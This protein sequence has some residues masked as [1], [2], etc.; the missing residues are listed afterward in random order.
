MARWRRFSEVSGQAKSKPSEVL[1]TTGERLDIGMVSLFREPAF[2]LGTRASDIMATFYDGLRGPQTPNLS[3]LQTQG[4]NS[5]ADLKLTIRTFGAQGRIEI[6]PGALLVG[7]PHMGRSAGKAEVA[8][9][10]LAWCEETLKSVLDGLE[11]SERLMRAS[12]WVSC[13]GGAA[14]V[15]TFLGKR[16]NEALNLDKGK[17]KKLKKEFTL[18]F[19]GL[20]A[21]RGVKIGLML[22]PSVVEGDLFGQFDY[23]MIGSPV[24]GKSVREQF[25]E[26]ESEL[27]GLL[28]QVGLIS[29]QK[30]A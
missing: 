3:D 5:Y 4:G 24:V 6:S 27:A 25:D 18:Q 15:E 7:L 2:Q 10:H 16:G 23:T 22:Q 9:E 30:H 1:Y 8:R 11:I 20:D 12:M 29:K 21:S 14:A 19:N 26:A 17:Y 28:P 13:E